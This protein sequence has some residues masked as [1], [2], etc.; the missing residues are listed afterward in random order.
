MQ[1]T[2]QNSKQ[3]SNAEN[4]CEQVLIGFGFTSD[5]LRITIVF[6]QLQSERK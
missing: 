1:G 5:W 6:K 2:N 4:A 3:A